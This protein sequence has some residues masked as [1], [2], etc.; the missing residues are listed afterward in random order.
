MEKR[1]G[2][3]EGFAEG[4]VFPIVFLIIFELLSIIPM[5]IGI[6]N[7][8][9]PI[10]QSSPLYESKSL[11]DLIVEALIIIIPTILFIGEPIVI[12]Y[13]SLKNGLGYCL[14]A[15][16]ALSLY[17]TQ[18]NRIFPEVQP[19]TIEAVILVILGMSAKLYV[20]SRDTTKTTYE[21]IIE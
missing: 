10:S 3:W 16:F 14:G 8:T 6:T 5:V 18:L 1:G 11:I 12:G 21:E 7:N 2:F 4:F 17:V 15:I 9:L 13:N 20:I 19:K